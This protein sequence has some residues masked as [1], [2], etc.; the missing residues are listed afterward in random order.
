MRCVS[1]QVNGSGQLSRWF[2]RQSGE[3]ECVEF[4]GGVQRVPAD[5]NTIGFDFGKGGPMAP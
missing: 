2:F 5:Q 1:A 4:P 3:L